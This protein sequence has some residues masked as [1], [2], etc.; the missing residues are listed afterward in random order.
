MEIRASFD[1]LI[2]SCSWPLQRSWPVVAKMKPLQEP[3]PAG[4]K[5]AHG[6]RINI[7]F[8]NGCNSNLWLIIILILLFG[9]EGFGCGCGCNNNNNCGCGGC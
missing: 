7:I 3:C 2:P 6:E 1:A 8:C 9:T 4:T 5:P